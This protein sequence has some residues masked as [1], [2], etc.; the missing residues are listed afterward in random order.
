M[1]LKLSKYIVHTSVIN[2]DD[3]ETLQ[4]RIIYSSVLNTSTRIKDSIFQK[5][6]TGAFN[7]VEPSIIEQLIGRNV[8]VSADK[9]EF[10]AILSEN[11]AAEDKLSLVINTSGNCQ[12]GCTYC[13]QKHIDKEIDSVII[14]KL[15]EYAED[16][17]KSRSHTKFDVVWD[18]GEA[19]LGFQ[20]LFKISQA[21]IKLANRYDVPYSAMLITNGVNLTK[22]VFETLFFEC[23]VKAYQVSI[24]GDKEAH[25]KKRSTKQGQPTFDIIFENIKSIIDGVPFTPG[26]GIIFQIKVNVDKVNGDG[27]GII[28]LIDR[29]AINNMQNRVTFKFAPVANY[30]A[31]KSRNSSGYET[32]EFAELEVEYEFHA[33][34]KGFTLNLLPNRTL[35]PCFAVRKHSA[36]IDIFGNMFSC[37]ALP[38]TEHILSEQNKIGNLLSDKNTFKQQT[39]FGNWF[40]ELEEKKGVCFDCNLFPVC[41]GGCR[42]QW[43]DGEIGCPSIK[44]N[45]EDRLVL[46]YLYRSSAINEFAAV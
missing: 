46:N 35:E 43:E 24:D 4:D 15:L 12:L 33:L 38:Y 8:L 14:E 5:L 3:K 37:Y 18:G 17:L 29:F 7:Q 23:N 22:D 44:Y 40:N 21:N 27:D 16:K 9:D 25:D 34:Q 32:A 6:I 36:A 10:T 39:K 41:G 13:G 19:L 11:K 28:D 26:D 31:N 20:N 45:I 2:P 30:A 1:N 42:L